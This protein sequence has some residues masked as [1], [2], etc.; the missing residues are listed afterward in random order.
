VELIEGFISVI[1]PVSLA[2]LALGVI[3]GTIVGVLPGIG[4]IGAMAILMPISYTFGASAGLLMLAGI[5]FGA[6]YGG[7]T[8]SILMRVPG[9]GS[10]VITAIDGYE[11]T[12][13]GR[14]GAAL[15]IAAVGSFVA[16]TIAT[17]LLALVAPGLSAVAIQFSAPEFFAI[18]LFALLVLSRLTGASMS[19]SMVAAALGLALGTIGFDGLTGTRRLDFGSLELAQGIDLTTVAVGLFGVAEIFFMIE[20]RAKPVEI[21]RVRFR[22]LYPTRTEW[23]R[24]FPSILRGSLIGFG[25]GLTP[26]PSAVLSTYASYAAEKRFSKH[27]HELGRGAVEGVAGPE[28]ANNAASGAALV[29]LLVLGIPFAAPTALLLSG[30]TV[31]AIIP[32][33]L[34]IAQHEALFYSLI[35]GLYLANLML[36]I[37]NFP[38]VGLFTRLLS[39]P[40]DLLI[41][42]ILI[43]A[44]I[45]VFAI[46][47]S[48][49]DVGV[50]LVMGVVGYGMAKLGLPRVTLVLAFVI[51]PRIESSFRQTMRLADGDLG[52]VASRPIAVVVLALTVVVLVLPAI[53]RSV[54][55]RIPRIRRAGASRSVIAT[56]DAETSSRSADSHPDNQERNAQ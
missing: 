53:R 6:M 9:E 49:F 37:L 48:L 46:R 1:T 54:R 35:A 20:R 14:G 38:L 7:S 42:M 41:V 11:M 22:E 44:M 3:V 24:S 56:G 28:S 36:L 30:L 2:A 21:A 25:L 27:R 17:T 34:F 39:I 12:K 15:V 33:P 47:Q 45:G 32:G 13:R 10:S 23:R 26:G 31:H 18:G 5:Y 4:P 55:G 19:R 52:F 43:V 29:P 40:R 50:L 8:T 16:G 51:G